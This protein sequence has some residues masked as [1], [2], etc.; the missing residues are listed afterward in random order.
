[1]LKNIYYP[2]F[3]NIILNTIISILLIVFF[4][5]IHLENFIPVTGDEL[6]SILVY[7]T[8]LK[9]LLLKNFPGNVPFFHFIGLVK[10][11]L[12]G[13]DLISY[14]SITY[15]LFL[16]HLYIFKIIKLDKNEIV[17]FLFLLICSNFS[18][19]LGLY[20]G[21]VF[22]SLL[23]LIIFYF[24]ILNEKKNNLRIILFLLFIQIYD[25]LVNLYLVIPILLSL[26]INSKEKKIFFTDFIIYFLIPTTSFYLIST[27]LTGLS[28][29]DL[30]TTSINYILIFLFDNTLSIFNTG[31]NRIFFYEAYQ[32]VE[33]FNLFNFFIDLYSFDKFIMFVFSITFILSLIHMKIGKKK[34]IFTFIIIFHF[35]TIFVIN[36]QPAARIFV[37]FYSFYIATLF[38]Y[39]KDFYPLIKNLV[40]QNYLTFFMVLILSLKIF[41]FNYSNLINNSIYSKD[42]TTKE[43]IISLNYL[44]KN[45][46]LKN[47]NYSEIQK[48][49]YFFNYL[50]ICKKNFDLNVFLNFYRS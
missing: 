49:N 48:R 5:K 35:F 42:L 39:M 4:Y 22:S 20:I 32:D 18:L 24:L 16:I 43:N 29:S 21:Y 38:Y 9:T 26:F 1:M 36:K 37:G 47:N 6:N 27:I 34:N 31:F 28:L 7:S 50:N 17:I 33:N 45:C 3:K 15:L 41:N 19:Y 11:K 40:K 8:N 13:Y 10:S 12:F 2:K 30:Q 23:Y 14:R 46:V 25:H 44:K